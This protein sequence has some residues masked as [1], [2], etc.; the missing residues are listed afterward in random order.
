MRKLLGLAFLVG[1][2]AHAD[3]ISPSS[4]TA[5]LGVGGSVTV[6]KTVTVTQQLTAPLDLFFLTDTTG[7]MSGAITN[8]RNG[9]NSVV[10]SVAGVASNAAFGAGEYKDQ[11]DAFA[12]RLNQDMTT[13]TALITTAMAAWVA[14][15]GGDTP[16]ANL[17]ALQQVANNTSWRPGSLR[18]VVWSGD[19]PGHD[20][21]GA[22]TEASATAALVAAGVQ[23][24]SASANSGPGID[25][26][27]QATRISNATG[28][29]FL[30]TLNPADITAAIIAAITGS[31]N[32]Y[33]VVSLDFIGLPA[34]VVASFTP[35][36]YTGAFDRSIDRTF[37]F[38]VVFTGLA[39]GVFNFETVA[40]VDGSI[41]AREADSLTVGDVP[42]PSAYAM[43][44][45][46]LLALAALRRRLS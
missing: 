22:A 41:V 42:E 2:L 38:D 45:G 33:S 4:L 46:G 31:I 30:G 14:S 15:G 44:A 7:S 3:T 28:G 5:T 1:S 39:P 34:G 21:S 6:N 35:L 13:N 12:Y 23:V 24:I 17:F 37:N 18:M 19:A 29:S 25:S 27:G 16:E 20:P 10:S 40:T 9:F 11:T 43:L 26:T 36:S 8:V 32:N